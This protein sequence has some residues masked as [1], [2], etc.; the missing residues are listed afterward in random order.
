MKC[1]N[2]FIIVIFYLDFLYI[3]KNEIIESPYFVK[4]SKFSHDVDKFYQ[5]IKGNST[6]A[7]IYKYSEIGVNF[8]KE[9]YINL[10]PFGK[11]L[12]DVV[13]EIVMELKQIGEIPS[14]KFFIDKWNELSDSAKYYYGY[15]N[16][17]Q[18]IQRIIKLIYLKLYDFE[19]TALQMENQ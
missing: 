17:E 13:N 18:R 19:T 4:F 6:I 11:E 7:A 9:K 8:V 15:F 3:T 16:F 1:F 10:I 2:K 12:M 5:D 14:V